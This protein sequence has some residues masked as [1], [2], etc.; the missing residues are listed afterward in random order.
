MQFLPGCSTVLQLI[1]VI[2]DWTWILD[3][4]NAVDVIYFN[5]M[6][7]F[8]K[9]PHKRLLEK[10]R[11]YRTEERCLKW[12]ETFLG[13]RKQCVIVSGQKYEWHAI[14]S[15]IHHGSVLRPLLF[16]MC[17]NYLPEVLEN[18]SKVY[19]YAD[20]TKVYHHIKKQNDVQKMQEDINFMNTWSGEWLLPFNPNNCKHMWI[21]SNDIGH[22]GYRMNG[23]I[24]SGYWEGHWGDHW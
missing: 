18:Q 23:E 1:K 8:D 6:K 16:V 3:E 15:G 13:N 4:G 5:F 24:T 10:L 2:D 9:V 17:I 12:I 11:I 22:E 19:L 20:D 7:A 14:K 21:D